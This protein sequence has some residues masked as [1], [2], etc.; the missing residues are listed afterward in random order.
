[1]RVQIVIK[2]LPVMFLSLILIL[3]SP[4]KLPHRLAC[5]MESTVYSLI[6]LYALILLLVKEGVI[7]V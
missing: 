7:Y 6:I 5:S 4:M 3:I 2:I 1:M